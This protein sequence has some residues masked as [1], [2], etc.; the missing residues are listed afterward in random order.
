M[1]KPLILLSN[2]DGYNS[3]GLLAAASALAELGDL[4]IAA[5]L[6]QQSGMGRAWLPGS[7][8]A[9]NRHELDINGNPH[10][11]YAVDGSP[12]QVIARALMELIPGPPD[13]M[14]SGINFGENLGMA[15]T[16][17]GTGG[18][19][20]ETA[21]SGIPSMA[22]SLE[23]DKKYY[24]THSDA[25][26][27]Q[28][29]AYFTGIFARRLLEID[30]PPDV[31]LLKIEVPGDATPDTPWVMTRVSRQRYFVAKSIQ[32]E[33]LEG[34]IKI[35]YTTDFSSSEPGTD[36]YTLAID[37]QVAVTPLSIDLTSRTSL[38]DLGELLSD[39]RYAPT[40]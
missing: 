18:A 40:T 11:A 35:D 1:T 14:V 28:T 8:G 25:V 21:I 15:T 3:P 29:A 26:D 17:S 27:F 2:D 5:P 32:R 6:T 31:D 38:K 22:V 36:T 20:M 13:L 4:F 16:A 33:T 24:H 10:L 12:S 30:L 19:A 23:V 37:R 7:S 34:P 9:I 39:G